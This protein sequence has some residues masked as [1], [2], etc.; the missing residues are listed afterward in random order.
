[1]V[2][3]QI[4]SSL[5][6]ILPIFVGVFFAY[7]VLNYE[8]EKSKFYIYLSFFYLT[9]YD[10]NKGFYLFTSIFTFMIFYNLF[11]EKIKNYLTCNNCILA[12]Y[13]I[14]AYL[15]HYFINVF[16]SYI[17]NQDIPLISFDY[18]YYIITDIILCI[19]LFKGKV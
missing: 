12:I 17:L 3:Y 11:A 9:I 15:G 2:F 6:T 13:V 4:I 5:Y 19:I 7:I 14:V 1:M 10:V 8:D 16:L 18:V